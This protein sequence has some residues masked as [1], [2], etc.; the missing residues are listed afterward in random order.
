[1]DNLDRVLRL[2]PSA[3]RM[4]GISVAR[5]VDIFVWRELQNL[6]EALT[7]LHQSVLAPSLSGGASPQPDS[8]ECLSDIHNDSHD[9]IV[10]F[11]LQ[12]F[13]NCCKLG[14][15]PHFV[16]V[17]RL[18]VLERVGPPA[19]ML[20]LRILPFWPDSFLEKMVIRLVT[21]V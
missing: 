4:R 8:V 16:D 2:C 12:S 14:V 20:V 3:A 6:F 18:L 21:K 19:S 15:E 17:D 10:S 1:M 5:E 11:I 13:A 7:D 9:F